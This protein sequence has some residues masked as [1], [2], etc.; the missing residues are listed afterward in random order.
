M[1]TS[2]FSDVCLCDTH[3]FDGTHFSRWKHHMLDHFRAMGPKVWWVITSGLTHVLDEENITEAQE[4]LYTLDAN[5]LC[6][7]MDALS[8]DV[9]FKVNQN[10]TAR[11]LWDSIKHTYGDASTWDDGK[12]EEVKPKV[13]AHEDVEHDDNKVVVED[14]ST[15]WS[16]DDD[17]LSTTRSLDKMDDEATSDASHHSTPSTLDGDDGSCSDDD[18]TT[19]SPSS[20]HCFMSQGDTK[21]KSLMKAFE[22]K[23]KKDESS[24]HGSN[25]QSHIVTNP[26]DVEKKN[27]ST[28]CDDLLDMPCS[29][30]IDPCS[31]SMSCETNRLKENN[32]LREQ[33]KNLSNKLERCYNS[34]VTFEHMLK[35]QK[36]YG[37]NCGLGFNKKS[38]T[39]SER[40]R[41]KKMKKLQ[42]LK[43]SHSMCYRC[44]EI[45]HLHFT[46]PNG[47][48]LKLKKEEVR[49]KH[50]KCFKCHTWGHLASIC[51]TK[52]FVKQQEK[53]QTKPQVEQEKKPQAQVK[54]NHE[55]KVDLKM[56]KKTRRGGRARNQIH[57]QDAKNM[58]SKNEDKKDLAH[59]KCFKC[60]DMGHFAS[61]CSNKLEKKTQAT[62][63]RQG[64]EEHQMSNG[65][66]A[67]PKRRC[68]SCR[69]R[70]HMAHSCPLGTTSKP[71]SINAN[72]I[73]R[74]DGNGT[75]LV[76]I[77]KHPAIH[78]M[79]L[80][81]YHGIGGLIQLSSYLLHLIE[82]S[83]EA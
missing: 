29:S 30:Q 67:L 58:M 41:E 47:A 18:T 19:S 54:I 4:A 43:L 61:K 73:L 60:G 21:F 33:V 71:I 9:F 6:Y 65:E 28:S 14:C 77:A 57:I 46:C 74:K 38:M 63:E 22:K 44:H 11:M 25:D 27:V 79:A 56:K 24:S 52:Q 8:S 12:Y 69:K 59:I 5:A 31:T 23:L 80:P 51:P 34:K 13:V 20:S 3:V 16:S 15:S 39:K 10:G 48:K 50:V 40:K 81:K 36:Y 26:C 35:T 68:Y 83:I 42:Q 66:K 70:R 7:L 37:D 17:D 55:T 82:S 2:G 78:T 32:E 64:N 76:A 62:H 75:S 53:P 49:L 72:N 45:G 1:A